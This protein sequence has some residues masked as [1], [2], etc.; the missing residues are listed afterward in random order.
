MGGLSGRDLE[1]IGR[2]AK[3]LGATAEGSTDS[4]EGLKG[5]RQLIGYLLGADFDST[6]DQQFSGLPAR[7]IIRRV[8]VANPSISL[9][10]AVGGIYAAPAKA[11]TVIVAATQT[12]ATLTGVSKF[13]DLPLEAVCGTDWFVEASI[14]FALSTPQGAPATADVF[15]FG[16]PLPAS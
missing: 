9:S 5:G 13:K 1:L 6:E 14:Y 8:V 3:R 12:Y 15:I 2:I 4:I 16:D 10:N 7:Y 11:G